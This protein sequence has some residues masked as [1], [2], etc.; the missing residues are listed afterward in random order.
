MAFQEINIGTWPSDGSGDPLRVSFDKIN[1][2]FTELY[3]KFDTPFFANGTPYSIVNTVAGKSGNVVLGV[4]DI[5]GA[6]SSA[7]VTNKVTQVVN[8]MLNNISEGSTT[9]LALINAVANAV[10]S[11]PNFTFNLIDQINQRVPFS[12]GT[13]TG[14]LILNADP[15][16]PLGASTKQFVDQSIQVATQQ[17]MANVN[18][19]GNTITSTTYTKSEVDQLLINIFNDDWGFVNESITS[20]DDFGVL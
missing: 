6:V 18:L 20:S 2:N 5:I 9:I 8:G 15:T 19:L 11:D 7:E 12:G 14:N 4:S 13:M 17:I 3:G 1:D 10:N 16:T